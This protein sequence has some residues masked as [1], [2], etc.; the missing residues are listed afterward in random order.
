MPEIQPVQAK[1][2]FAE[3]AKLLDSRQRPRS[4]LKKSDIHTQKKATNAFLA[5]MQGK[6][7][8]RGA[9]AVRLLIAAGIVRWID[10]TNKG[11]LRGSLENPDIS[12]FLAYIFW[13]VVS[14]PRLPK[15]WPEALHEISSLEI[16]T[17][18]MEARSTFEPQ[19]SGELFLAFAR[20]LYGA[21]YAAGVKNLIDDLD[22]PYGGRAVFS[23]LLLSSDLPV[24]PQKGTGHRLATWLV[25][26]ATSGIVGNAAWEKLKSSVDLQALDSTLGAS[27]PPSIDIG[28]SESSKSSS[29]SS[30]DGNHNSSE[31]WL[32][33]LAQWLLGMFHHH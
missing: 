18:V 33:H 26:S 16:C 6:P 8:R 24:P 4:S 11:Y 10:D 31:G 30:H 5:A 15:D 28:S 13:P 3:W 9:D 32:H 29:N 20:R 27:D 22:N 19:K 21:N 23:S 1:I 7:P 12:E 14:A 2:D 17:V 25:L